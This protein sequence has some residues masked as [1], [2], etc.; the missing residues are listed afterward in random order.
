MD[1]LQIK[2]VYK[3]LFESLASTSVRE[4]TAIVEEIINPLVLLNEPLYAR[5]ATYIEQSALPTGVTS[6]DILSLVG[7]RYLVEQRSGSLAVVRV[8][9]VFDAPR[10]VTVPAS[11]V[12]YTQ[13]R[14]GYQVTR[15]YNFAPEQLTDRGDGTYQTPE[16]DLQAQ[17]EGADYSVEAS[18]ITVPGFT[19][20]GL[21]FCTNGSASVG[22][23]LTETA[24][25]YYERIR[26][27]ISS[28]AMDTPLGLLS[29]AAEQF[30]G[31]ISRILVVGAGDTEMTRDQQFPFFRVRQ[32]PLDV[33][34][35]L[36]RY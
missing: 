1:A 4:G 26:L 30:S 17:A 9:L 35:S 20:Q 6:M 34:I 18:E 14:R 16:I 28:R 27:A 2:S 10:T 15:S 13:D 23:A 24:Q 22:G 3:D 33:V 12:C 29:V 36:N 25:Q 8:N 32:V 7:Q 11:A 5:V 21:L 31:E 19:H